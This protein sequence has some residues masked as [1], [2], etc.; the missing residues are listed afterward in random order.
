M[1]QKPFST[2]GTQQKLQ[3][4][5]KY[6]GFY[7]TALGGKFH[8]TYFDAFAGTGDIPIAEPLPLFDGALEIESVV[9]GSASRALNL[10]RPFDR[11][12]LVDKRRSNIKSLETLKQAHVSIGNRIEL[13]H[14]DANVAIDRFCSTSFQP[15]ARQRA[16]IFL[17]PFGNQV[18][19]KTLEKIAQTP[20]IDLWYLFSIRAWC[21]P[22]T[23]Q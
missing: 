10:A 6:L 18:V 22:S 14:D 12:V 5:E 8:L 16:V 3:T 17:D 13:I 19:W 2:G 21:L 15:K 11:Y 1:A 4:L 20:G 7:T 9:E 23:E